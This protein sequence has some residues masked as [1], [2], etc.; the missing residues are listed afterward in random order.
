METLYWKT[1]SMQ[2]K[3]Y[4]SIL[5][6][7]APV[8]DR[9]HINKWESP[10]WLRLQ[11]YVRRKRHQFLFSWFIC[12]WRFVNCITFNLLSLEILINRASEAVYMQLTC[13]IIWNTY[14]M[15]NNELNSNLRLMKIVNQIVHDGCT[16]LIFM[17]VLSL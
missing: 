11:I 17:F 4:Q 6:V 5:A 16:E 13:Q 1:F 15:K 9:G 12:C 3:I 7:K 14:I 10:L 8:S 2:V